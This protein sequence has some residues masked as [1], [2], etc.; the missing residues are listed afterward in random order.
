M[1]CDESEWK[2]LI[3]TISRGNLLR[4]RMKAYKGKIQKQ[5]LLAHMKVVINLEK[6]TNK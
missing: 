4:K 5:F 2:Q 3:V 1:K 6:V